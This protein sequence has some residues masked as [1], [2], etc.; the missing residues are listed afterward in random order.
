MKPNVEKNKGTAERRYSTFESKRS[1]FLTR[2]QKCSKLSIPSLIPEQKDGVAFIS[3]YQSLAAR[4]VNNLASK[5]M[6]SLLPPNAPFFKLKVDISKLNEEERQN[7]EMRQEMDKGLSKVERAVIE[8]IAGTS[9]RVILFESLKHLIVGGNALLF[10]DPAGGMKCYH[11]DSYVVRRDGRGEVREIIVKETV[12]LDALPEATAAALK[13]DN[14][15]G[16][17]IKD[18]YD[19]YTHIKR[20]RGKWTVQQE[21]R[22]IVVEKSYGTYPLDACPWIAMRLLRVDGEDYGRSYVEEY[23]GDITSLDG[24]CQAIVEGSAAAAKVVFLLHPNATTRDSD[25]AESPNLGFVSGNKNDIDILQLEKYADFRVARET[26]VGIEQRLEHAFILN[27]AIQRNGERVTREEI[28]KMAED[29][30]AALGGVYS[31]LAVEFQTPYIACKLRQLTKSGKIPPMPKGI[32]KPVIVTGVE[33]IGRGTDK[34]KLL[35]MLDVAQKVL[36][37][38]MMQIL[39]V[40]NIMTRLC[41]ALGVDIEGL[42]VPQEQRAEQQQE[43]QTQQNIEALGPEAM[44]LMGQAM[45][46]DP[47]ML[48]QLQPEV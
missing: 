19:L 4:G 20:E 13:R 16:S 30:E 33:A 12:D 23:Y 17:K 36:G 6:L 3:P 42:L 11:L 38:S 34:D 2:A 35:E 48:Q 31:L 10:V 45:Q 22:G 32:V 5:L 14:Q 41:T 9:D 18:E 47:E 29:L 21:V 46:Q 7:E 8:E 44:K 25:L 1:A 28:R 26:I 27:S 40:E 15:T 39:N 24:L 43:A 37:P